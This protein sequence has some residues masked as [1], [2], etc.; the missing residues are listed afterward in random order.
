MAGSVASRVSLGS[1]R[2]VPVSS[3]WPVGKSSV[4]ASWQVASEFCAV[5]ADDRDAACLFGEQSPGVFPS[6]DG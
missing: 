6:L 5:S 3:S 4:L 1:M 2:P